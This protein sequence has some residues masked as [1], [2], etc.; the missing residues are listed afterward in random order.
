MWPLDLSPLRA[1]VTG[2]S[3]GIGLATAG[4]LLRAGAAVTICGRDGE[5]LAAAERALRVQHGN[6]RLLAVSHAKKLGIDA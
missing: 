4:L 1:I 3:S 5:R 2:G 6:A